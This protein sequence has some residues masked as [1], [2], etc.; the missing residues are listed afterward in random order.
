MY[1]ETHP[2]TAITL[3]TVR[4]SGTHTLAHVLTKYWLRH[5]LM[6]EWR[7]DLDAGG[8]LP[9]W[10][11]HCEPG[12]MDKLLPRCKESGVVVTTMRHPIDVYW[13]W[14]KRGRKV[15]ERFKE[16]WRYLFRIHDE[17]EAYFV[18]VDSDNRDEHLAR[19]SERVG[20]ELETDWPRLNSRGEIEKPLGEWEG[21]ISEDE[22]REFLSQFDFSPFGYDL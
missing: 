6:E 18:P 20:V 13:S 12:T 3:A 2:N 8:C 9:M 15:D 11:G 10:F 17:F 7:R 1:V 4:H 5:G 16:S 22:A 19:L 14:R 21:N